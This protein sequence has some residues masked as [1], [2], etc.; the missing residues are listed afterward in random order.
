MDPAIQQFFMAQ[1]QLIQNLTAT[2]QNL[3]AQ[4]NQPPPQGPPPPPPPLNKHIEFISHH[5]P[6][7]SHSVD[8]LDVDDCLKTINKK[9]NITQCNDQEKVLYA[10]GCLEGA[11]ADWWDAYTVAHAAANTITWQEFP[12]AFHTHHIPSGIIKLKQKEFLALKQGNMFVIEY[13]DKFTQLTR[14]APDEVDTDP[15]RQ[16]CFLDGLIGPLNYQLQSHTFPNFQTL[17]DMA[18]GL[19]SKRRELGEQKRKFQSQGQS[20]SNARPLYNAPQNP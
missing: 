20:S 10:S 19:E 6:T 3:Q 14:Y 9:L 2:I 7:Y 11:T 4:Q 5:P 18:I 12:E 1:M 13:R 17:L 16:E 8:P 15:K